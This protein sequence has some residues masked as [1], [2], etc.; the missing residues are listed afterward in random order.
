MVRNL[1]PEMNFHPNSSDISFY[2]YTPCK[3]GTMVCVRG[4]PT[5]SL[6]DDP[7]AEVG[8]PQGVLA[9]T[10]PAGLIMQEVVEYDNTRMSR[11]MSDF[12]VIMVGS[13]V[14]VYTKG[15]ANTKCI[16]DPIGTLLAGKP[17]Y[18]DINGYFT[19][20]GGP[21]GSP[22]VGTFQS[23]RDANGF[24]RVYIDVPMSGRAAG[25]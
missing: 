9:D 13:K 17:A 5:G 23:E 3:D 8:P 25:L 20:V 12:E 24:A 18:Y 10:I 15:Y 4:W 7:N 1:L 21:T 2:C 19:T 16:A 11:D 6:W 14:A 22:C